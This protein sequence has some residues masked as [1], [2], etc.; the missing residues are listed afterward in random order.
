[1]D[2]QDLITLPLR[3]LPTDVNKIIRAEQ[4]RLELEKN[5]KLKKDHVVYR[6]IREWYHAKSANGVILNPQG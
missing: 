5:K 1:M 4:L 3:D 6:I 2:K